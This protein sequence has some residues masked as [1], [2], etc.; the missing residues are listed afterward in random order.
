[1]MAPPFSDLS[2]F[3]MSLMQHYEQF[4]GADPLQKMRAKAWN[5][6]LELGLPSKKSE[7]FRYIRWRNLFEKQFILS[8]KTELDFTTIQPHIFPECAGSVLVFVNG[9]YTPH[10]SRMEALPKRMVVSSLNEAVKTYG[11]FL[12]NQWTKSLKD[13]NDPFAALNGALHNDGLFIY[14][15]PKM[16][17]ETPVQILHVIDAASEFPLLISP[18]IQLFAGSQTEIEIHST[19]AVL[20]GDDYFVNMAADFALEEGA[21]IYYTQTS[22]NEPPN[23]WHFDALRAFLRKNSTLKTVSSTEGG[24][25]VRNDYRIILGGENGE[26]LLNGVWML[27]EKREAHVH[28]IVDHQAPSCRSMQLYKGVLNDFGHSSFEGKILVKQEAQKTEAFQLNNNLLLSDRASADSKPN[29][30]IFADDV[31]ASHGATVGKLDEEQLFYMKTRGFPL[32]QAQNILVNGF[33]REVIDKITLSSLHQEV[34][35]QAE[36]FLYPRG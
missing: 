28:V 35:R 32:Q 30:E 20:S 21:H 17:L 23:G 12:N 4:D 29:L 13:E 5:R 9:Y 8:D 34:C 16:V 31:K 15:P 26:A 14:L 36:S 24:L 25:T 2:S 19:Q 6:F 18:R 1:M 3:Q 11:T 33:C 22:S 27:K 10:L 7:A